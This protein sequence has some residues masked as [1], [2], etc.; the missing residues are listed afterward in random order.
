MKKFFITTLIAIALFSCRKENNNPEIIIPDVGLIVLNEGF[1][2]MNNASITYYSFETKTAHQNVFFNLND[3]LL[4]DTPNDILIYGGKIY[5]SV[6]GSSTLVI[7]DL[8]FNFIKQISFDGETINARQ[9]HG[10]ASHNGKIFIACFDGKLARL[11]TSTLEIDRIISVGKNPENI[12]ISN[13]FA[14]VT[15]SGGLDGILNPQNFDS[16]V[17]V[18]NLATFTEVKKIV[19]GKNPFS[20]G[21]DERGDII[22]GCRGD[23]GFT[24]PFSLHRINTSDHSVYTFQNVEPSDFVIHKSTIY[25]YNVTFTPDWDVERIEYIAYNTATGTKTNLLVN[26]NL[27]QMPYAINVNREN[28]NIYISC[29]MT[30]RVFAFDKNGVKLFDF[31]AGEMPKKIVVLR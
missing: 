30:Q 20:I 9:P 10:L 6:G 14:Y 22:V 31:E 2:G 27:I 16:T 29:S 23:Y 1:W 19:V 28:E 5:I 15:N 12:A 7:T 24:F 3:R 4:G 21:V 25:F 8:E 26:S 13:G 17:S 18:V 11:D